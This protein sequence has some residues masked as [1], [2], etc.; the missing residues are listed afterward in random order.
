MILDILYKQ[1]TLKEMLTK[2]EETKRIKKAQHN[3]SQQR[4]K[5]NKYTEYE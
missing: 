5:H 3:I 4:I 2:L 1:P